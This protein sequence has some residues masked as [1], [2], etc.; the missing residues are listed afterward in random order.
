MDAPKAF[1]S[2]RKIICVRQLNE[3]NSDK[4]LST[5]QESPPI[6]VALWVEAADAEVAERGGAEGTAA[7][8]P[9]TSPCVG[10]ANTWR[11]W[12]R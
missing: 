11:P 8:I 10:A 5:M 4:S 3:S 1:L 9:C 2:I 6:A 12:R 7:S